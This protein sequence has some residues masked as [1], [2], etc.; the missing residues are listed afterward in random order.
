MK[1]ASDR[2]GLDPNQVVAKALRAHEVPGSK[3]ELRL[4]LVVG[5]TARFRWRIN[6]VFGLN[7]TR[8]KN[9]MRV[10][11][12][13]L[14]SGQQDMR[15]GGRTWQGNTPAAGSQGGQPA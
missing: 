5:G 3:A 11:A 4:D 10:L 12:G 13:V 1:G 7:R 9:A 2:V 8:T 14:A 6:P 15:R